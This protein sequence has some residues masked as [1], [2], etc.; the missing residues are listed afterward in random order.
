MTEKQKERKWADNKNK[1][2]SK[3]R[4]NKRTE[5]NESTDNVVCS[6]QQRIQFQLN[7]CSKNVCNVAKS[8]NGTEL[9]KNSQIDETG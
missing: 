5:R 9:M 3:N 2:K 8:T 6:L 4:T 7:E 1:N